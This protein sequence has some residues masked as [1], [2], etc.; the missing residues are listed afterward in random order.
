VSEPTQPRGVLAGMRTAGRQPSGDPNVAAFLT[1]FIPGAGHVY[2]GRLT[3][4]LLG[5]AA[6]QGLYILGLML[7]GGMGFE[8]LQ[9]ELRGPLA[10]VLG[11][12]AGNLGGFLWQM[13]QYGYGPGFPRPWPEWISLG[14]SLTAISGIA[15]VCLMVR[16]HTLARLPRGASSPLRSAPAFQTLLAWL[17][18][19]LGHLAQGRRLRAALVFGA[20]VGLLV[21]GT[22]L[23]EGSNL[24]RERHYYYWGGQLLAGMPALLLEWIHGHGR[25]AGEIPLAEAGLVFG[26]LAGLLNVL[27]MIDVYGGAEREHFGSPDAHEAPAGETPKASPASAQW[28]G[29]A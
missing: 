18:P 17:V 20:L 2:L 16:A 15:N 4:G 8:Y 14:T 11:P 7:S 29:R 23:A 24:D 12:E 13:R 25:V 10:P 22:L 1:W 28:G 5:F 27:A 9:P 3:G 26:C 19:G 21:L 6:V